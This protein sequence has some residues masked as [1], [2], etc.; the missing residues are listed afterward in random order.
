MNMDFQLNYGLD[1]IK[2][3][4]ILHFAY[5]VHHS[6]NCMLDSLERKY[7]DNNVKSYKLQLLINV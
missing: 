5:R 6:T 7:C 1:P 2:F 4:I 3:S